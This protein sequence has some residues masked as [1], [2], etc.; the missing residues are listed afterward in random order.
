MLLDINIDP[1]NYVITHWKDGDTEAEESS[2][3]WPKA[4][5]WVDSRSAQPDKL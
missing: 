5:H 4:H 2:T 1:V 3:S